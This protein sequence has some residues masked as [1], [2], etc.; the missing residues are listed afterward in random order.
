MT[1]VGHTDGLRLARLSS[2]KEGKAVAPDCHQGLSPQ[3]T[4]LAWQ[5]GCARASYLKSPAG[6]AS[7]RRGSAACS[8]PATAA[9]QARPDTG[10]MDSRAA[11]WAPDFA[12]VGSLSQARLCYRVLPLGLPSVITVISV[13]E[14]VLRPLEPPILA[15]ME[16]TMKSSLCQS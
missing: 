13:P 9:L 7:A 2:R 4:G 11:K 8:L 12:D 15:P 1:A 10:E 5:E 16:A 6:L 14:R 3:L